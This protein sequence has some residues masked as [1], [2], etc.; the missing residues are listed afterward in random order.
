MHQKSQLIKQQMDQIGFNNEMINQG[1]VTSISDG[2][3]SIA[4]DVMSGEMLSFGDGL[5][6]LAMNLEEDNVGMC[7]LV[8]MTH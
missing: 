1:F 2:A 6:G 3:M 5:I 8:N 4:G 7:L